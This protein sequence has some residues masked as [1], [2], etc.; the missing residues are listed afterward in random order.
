MP[1][2]I[3]RLYQQFFP[4]VGIGVIASIYIP[5]DSPHRA[6]IMVDRGEYS[7]EKQ[8]VLGRK[9]NTEYRYT[10]T[11]QVIREGWQIQDL[12]YIGL[13]GQVIHI[14]SKTELEKLDANIEEIYKPFMDWIAWWKED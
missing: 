7:E 10:P 14:A 5:D 13:L 3:K 9:Q 8:R 6:R 4:H 11:K 12:V 2:K 1:E